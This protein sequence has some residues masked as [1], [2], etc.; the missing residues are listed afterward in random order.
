[1]KCSY[2]AEYSQYSN[3][4][5]VLPLD[6]HEAASSSVSTFSEVIAHGRLKTEKGRNKIKSTLTPFLQ[7]I[8]GAYNVLLKKPIDTPK[9]SKNTCT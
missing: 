5:L 1:M 9:V 8:L 7:E 6:D 3:T 4:C 2:E